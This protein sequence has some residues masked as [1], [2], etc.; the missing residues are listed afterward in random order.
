MSELV[1]TSGNEYSDHRNLVFNYC[2]MNHE[3]G[4]CRND[5]HTTLAEKARAKGGQ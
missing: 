2:T 1:R 3:C 4:G 5:H